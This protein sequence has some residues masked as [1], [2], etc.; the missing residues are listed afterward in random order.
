MKAIIVNFKNYPEIS[1]EGS[2]KLARA[3]AAVARKVSVEIIVSPPTPMLSA[4]ASE[5]GVTVYAQ[6]VSDRVGVQTTGAVLP[7]SV[8]GSGATGTIL[9]HSEARKPRSVLKP[10]VKRLEEC[11][12]DVCLCARTAEEASILSSIGTRFLAVEPPELIGSGVAVSKAKPTL[13]TRTVSAVRKAGYRGQ[14]LVGAGIVSG[15]DV[16]K[17]VELGADGVL[18]SSSVV[19][20]ADWAGKIEELARSLV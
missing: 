9:N 20:S 8:K 14:V 16:S 2:L 17:A 6:D 5:V 19:K 3:A 10:L 4:V 1:G 13:V 11:G 18:V 12:L 15:E 7:E